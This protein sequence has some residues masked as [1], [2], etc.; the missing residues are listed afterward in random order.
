MVLLPMDLGLYRSVPM[1]S[2]SPHYFALPQGLLFLR[3]RLSPLYRY[4]WAHQVRQAL[5]RHPGG[6]VF[7]EQMSRCFLT[8]SHKSNIWCS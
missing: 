7:S 4:L 6:R 8:A 2:L 3:H 1:V 5:G